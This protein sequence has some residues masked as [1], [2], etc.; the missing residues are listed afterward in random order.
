[1]GHGELIPMNFGIGPGSDFVDQS[2]LPHMRDRLT[3]NCQVIFVNGI[4]L[5]DQVTYRACAE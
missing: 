4:N 2:R 1:M 3:E 5:G